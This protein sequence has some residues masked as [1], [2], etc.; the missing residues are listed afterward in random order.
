MVVLAAACAAPG[1]S[2]A[3]AA[4][5]APLPES[6]PGEATT[7]SFAASEGTWMTV[8]ASPRDGSLV[9]DLLGDLYV[10]PAQGGAATPLLRGPA[11]EASPAFSP[12]GR[13][14][15][16]VSDRSGSNNLWVMASD[17]TGLRQLSH[18][19][20]VEVYTS[21]AW[22]PDGS[23]IYASRLEQTVQAFELHAFAFAGGEGVRLTRAKPAG[24]EGFDQSVG[25][26]SAAPSAD[27]RHLYYARRTGATWTSLREVAP[28]AIHRRDLATGEDLP[29]IT[30]PTGAMRPV[31]SRDGRYL[32]Y[33]ARH[34]FRTG[35]RL[36]DLRTQQ[37]RWLAWPVD[38][39]V[40]NGGLY[41]GAYA[42][43]LP[44]FTFAADGG[45]LIAAVDGGLRRIP[46]DGSPAS[47]LP[48]TAPVELEVVRAPRP[49]QPE[50]EGPVVAR[51][52]QAPKLSP[53]GGRLAFGAFGRVH[54]QA[55]R[56]GAEPVVVAGGDAPAFQPD[57]SPDGRRLAYVTWT[58]SGGGA[59]HVVPASGGRARTLTRWP[60][61]HLQ[62]VF[63]ADGRD[64]FVLRGSHV[65]RLRA[66]TETQPNRST[67]LLRIPL[68]AP[69]RVEVV[70]S[71]AGVRSLRRAADGRLHVYT[72]QGLVSLGSDGRDRRTELVVNAPNYSIFFG[73]PVAADDIRLDTAGHR[74]LVRS[75][76]QVYLVQVPPAIDGGARTLDLGKPLPGRRLTR[77][78]ADTVEWDPAGDGVAWSLGAGFRRLPLDAVPPPGADAAQLPADE[79]GS[80]HRIVVSMPRATPRGTLLLR[81]GTALTQ[82]G[83]EAI[84]DADVLVRD[85]RIVAI[86][87][88]GSVAVPA[89]AHVI[90]VSG[91][92]LVPGFVDTHAHWNGVRREVLDLEDWI[93][94]ANLAY[95]ITAG[96]DVQAF[97]PDM[98]AYRDLVDAGVI[99]GPRAYSVGRGIFSDN[100]LATV[101]EARDVVA[102]YVDH[103]RTPNLKAYTVGNRA[104]R[105]RLARAARELGAIATTEGAVDLRLDM[106]HAID[107]F[108]GT[109]HNLPV[110]PV[111]DDL[112]RLFAAT[113]IGYT[114]TLQVLFG[115]V[116]AKDAMTIAHRDDI[117]DRL[118]RFVPEAYIEARTATSVAENPAQ[119]AYPRFAADAVAL[120]RA[121]G[122]VG[123]G[124]HGEFPGLAYHWELEAYAAGGAT[125]TEVLYAATRLSAEVIGR[126]GEI[127]SL[128]PGKL[129]DILV[130][131]RDPRL[132]V[133]HA[134]ALRYVVRGGRV[135]AADTLDEVWPRQVSRSR[136]WFLGAA[137]AADAPAAP[138]SPP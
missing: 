56:D 107:G 89:E 116:A 63:S 66:P 19:R 83:D 1:A 122:L 30:I 76:A 62:P 44:G 46:L 9:F 80:H 57:W 78:G 38:Q 15:A 13:H 85:D 106:T 68:D 112:L 82:R 10:M 92:F 71:F 22:S 25:A 98:F 41:S 29:W 79:A 51:V 4:A 135:H 20:G 42:D 100:P 16:F 81:G 8:D 101:E 35:L 45:A 69:E 37:D 88:R 115:G 102:R 5:E 73:A 49:S 129:A 52:I 91:R 121:G 18:D 131:D 93:L 59:V 12:D 120:Q 36:R 3:G 104:Q 33:A 11:F 23:R 53:D 39:D 14:V 60:A 17:G 138:G 6:A 24:H 97:S 27:G 127:G 54:V 128:E 123:M 84:A 99:A 28:W 134:R 67:D 124:S 61:F 50:P 113:R 2:D 94:P 108:A 47:S 110:A 96:L 86:G 43:T 31:V 87:A 48:F 109:E 64:L 126:H 136:P 34:A 90:D 26:L 137:P 55:L 132:D 125:P 119:L 114:P 72:P 58:A 65:D 75:G 105:R 111:H 40:Q 32:A 77:F 130:L 7:L 95:G 117:D 118:R 70:A 74:A 133:R 21:P 103:Y